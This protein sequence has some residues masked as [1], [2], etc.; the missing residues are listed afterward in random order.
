M[1]RIVFSIIFIHLLFAEFPTPQIQFNPQKY[2]CYRTINEIKVDGKL[3][4]NDWALVPWTS[5]F[6]DIEGD[7]KPTPY[8]DTKVKML[9]DE[10]YFYIA[11]KMEENH[12]WSTLTERDA[13]IFYDNDFEVFIDPDGDSHNYYELE[14]NTLGTEWDLLLLKPYRDMSRVAVD[15]WD[16]AGLKTAVHLDGTINNPHD[17]DKGWSIEIAIPWKVLEECALSNH[18]KDGEQWRVNFSRVQWTLD[19]IDGQYKKRDVPEHNWVWSPQGLIAMHYPEMWGYVQFSTSQVG[20]N[21]IDFNWDTIEDHKWYIRQMYYRQKQHYNEH[22]EW[23][24]SMMHLKNLTPYNRNFSV[25]PQIQLTP[26]GYIIYATMKDGREIY[27][28][29]D[30]LMKVK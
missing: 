21:N 23:M 4:E 29:Q 5:S 25:F 28:R 7:L 18:P 27:C 6:V 13:V 9:W 12:L 2:I 8:F 26:E 22:G 16:I 3:D 14:V 17:E 15:S 11:S 10:N 19:V 24:G 30:G 1:N 20:N